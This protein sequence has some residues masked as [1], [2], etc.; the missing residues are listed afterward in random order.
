MIYLAIAAAI[1]IGLPTLV[2]I[3]F[4][5]LLGRAQGDEAK[6]AQQSNNEVEVTRG[7]FQTYKPKQQPVKAGFIFYI[8]GY[9]YPESYGPLM[10]R[11]AKEGYFCVVLPALTN[12][13]FM[14]RRAADKVFSA[15]P[16]VEHWFVGGHSQGA[17]A[18]ALYVRDR[19]ADNPKIKGFVSLGCFFGERLGLAKVALPSISIY[20]TCDGLAHHFDKF[21]KNLPQPSTIERISGG[22]HKGF[23]NYIRHF[24]DGVAEISRDEQQR[25]T[26]NQLSAFFT[27]NSV[28]NT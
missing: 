3:V 7:R 16:E 24:K 12:T 10:Q 28:R 25:I 4:W 6:L 22:N 21:S 20:G 19:S 23:A 1:L 27:A 8:G 9:V 11:L 17:A 15:F 5:L 26:A 14:N 2:H 18:A 13:A